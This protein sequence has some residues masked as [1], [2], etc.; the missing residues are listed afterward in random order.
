VVDGKAQP[1]IIDFGIAKAIGYQLTDRTLLTELGAVIGTP[2]YMSPEQA[3]S[4]GRDVDTRSDV[5]SLGVVLYQLLSGEL[6]FPS[7]ELRAFSFDEMRRKLRE[8]EPPCPSTRLSTLGD[9]AVQVAQNRGTDPTTLRHQLEGDL[10]A[11]TLKA[12]EKDRSRRY[13]SALEM[14]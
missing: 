5:Y 4:T 2:E 7:S 9:A 14:A 13:A 3:D 12:L 10:D 11:I 1:K 6:P 8:D